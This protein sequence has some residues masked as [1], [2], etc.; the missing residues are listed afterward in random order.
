MNAQKAVFDIKVLNKLNAN[1]VYSIIL[2]HLP[3]SAKHYNGKYE[4]VLSG[5]GNRK[6]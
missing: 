5:D 2:M 4:A 1:T 3:K 6:E